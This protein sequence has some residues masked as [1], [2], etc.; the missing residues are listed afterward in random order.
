MAWGSLQS[1]KS[2]QCHVALVGAF[3]LCRCGY[4]EG[5]CML[6]CGVL[7]VEIGCCYVYVCI[8]PRSCVVCY[9]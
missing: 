9:G 4:E 2:P 3:A 1:P 7:Q 8:H 6:M 5:T